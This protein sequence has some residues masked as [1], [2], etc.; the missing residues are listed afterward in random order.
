MKASSKPG[1]PPV[2]EDKQPPVATFK[3]S[4]R[5]WQAKYKARRVAQASVSGKVHNQT[6][7]A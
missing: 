2:Q 7:P 1:S 5:D 6:A 4:L 3:T